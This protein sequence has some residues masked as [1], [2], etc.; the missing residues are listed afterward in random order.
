M[1]RITVRGHEFNELIIKDSYDRRALQF[2]NTIIATLKKIGLTEDDMEVILPRIAR[3]KSPAAASWYFDDRNMYFSYKSA[4]TFVQNLYVVLKV[5]EAEV[6][7]LLKEEKPVEEFISDFAEDRD[8]EIQRQ[9]ARKILGV[10]ENCFDIEVINKSYKLLAKQQHPD[11]GGD[12]EKFKE[13][14][15]A[16]KMLKR[17]LG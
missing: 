16:H 7:L 2:K 1:A 12:L 6:A 13:I 9:K 17:E 14:N 11:L 3:M 8:V 15:N 4:P 10:E 5:I